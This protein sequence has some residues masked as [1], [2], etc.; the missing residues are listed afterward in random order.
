MSNPSAQPDPHFRAKVLRRTLVAIAIFLIFFFGILIYQ[1]YALQLRDAELYRTE[2]VTQQM[3]D[4]ELPATARS[5]YSANGKLLAKSNTVWNII[6]N[7]LQSSKNGRY[8]RPAAGSRIP[9]C[10]TA[11]RRHHRRQRV[12]DAHRDQC[13]RGTV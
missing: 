11:G 13:R 8:D 12:R 7:P 10:G 9:H 1:L 2:A 6:A 3:Q 4:T 5:I